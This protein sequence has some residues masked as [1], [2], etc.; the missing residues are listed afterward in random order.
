MV[1]TGRALV[2]NPHHLRPQG[3][4][5]NPFSVA[6]VVVVVV[7]VVVVRYG[8]SVI[9][10]TNQ[11]PSIS[12]GVL[13]CTLSLSLPAGNLAMAPR[14]PTPTGSS[15][16]VVPDDDG[17]TPTAASTTTMS[18]SK[19][20]IPKE[21]IPVP[22]RQ[23]NTFHWELNILSAVALYG[24][25]EFVIPA[26]HRTLAH[27]VLGLLALDATRYYYSRGT[28]A[29]VPYTLPLVTI[30]A[31]LARPVRFW[32]ELAH[33]ALQSVDG[34]CANQLVGNF[35]V[36]VTDPALCREIMTGEADYGIYAHPNAM[37]LFGEKNLIYIASEPHKAIRAILTP[38]LFSKN[39]LGLYA[40]HQERVVRQYLAKFVEIC[41]QPGKDAHIDALV[42][43]RTMAAASSQ[44][45]FLGPYL[46]DDLRH[47]L[48]QDIVTFTMG[49]LSFPFPY[50]GGLRRAIQAKNRIEATVHDVI[51]KA[52]AWVQAGNEPRCLLEFWSLA[53]QNAAK[54]QNVSAQEVPGCQ[55]DDVA[56]T[57]LDFLF[58]A[59]DATNSALTYSLD[60]LGGHRNVLQSMRNEVDAEC[61]DGPIHAKAHAADSLVYVAKVANQMLHHKPPVPMIPHICKRN[62]TL[63]G[64]ALKKGTVV[65]PSITYS[66]RVGGG[67]LEFNPLRDDADAQ[68]V[69]TVTF[70][71]GQ[72]KCPGRKYAESLLNVF[73]A[74]LAQEYD[75]ERVADQ[76]P[77]VDDFIYFPTVFPTDTRFVIQK[78][79]KATE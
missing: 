21:D 74:V 1:P 36:F 59:Q 62:V 30:L 64:H 23:W 72:H 7:F 56:R 42:S 25:Y 10:H 19:Q 20:R 38:A 75:F 63:A 4:N 3:P 31:M 32:T 16:S 45:A 57:V 28:L 43:F 18:L 24:V 71:A 29:G 54:E 61:G 34:L 33:I 76:R 5:A 35:M 15:E 60:V 77:G 58:A 49:F 70:G 73:M 40:M 44:E 48:E 37:W 17:A 66:A 8:L 46:N 13:R 69:K 14:A 9:T 67:S 47:H 26:T 65:I 51:P 2:P 27:V 55:D 41:Q 53:I 11:H 68:F 6:F 79:V 39:A 52:R 12:F 22:L 50:L 78:R